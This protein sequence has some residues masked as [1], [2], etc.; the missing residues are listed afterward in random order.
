VLRKVIS[1][2][3]YVVAGFFVYM[4]SFVAFLPLDPPPWAKSAIMGGC[5]IPGVITLVIG[6]VISR[7]Q[8]W[9]RD[10]GIVLVSGA[11]TSALI[12]L[13]MACVLLSPELVRLHP[14]HKLTF[15]S[16][17]VTG[18]SCIVLFSA[19]G[20]TLIMSSR[21]KEP[22]HTLQPTRASARG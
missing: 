13:L 17:L 8:Y 22:N 12:I 18:L 2:I 9:K 6:L 3:C 5:A 1:I 16:H 15:F 14:S 10:V 4:V 11:G 19:A 21:R 7:F 20:I